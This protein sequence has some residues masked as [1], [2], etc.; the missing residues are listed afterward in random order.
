M[1]DI[2]IFIDYRSPRFIDRLR[3][4]IRSRNLSYATE[5]TYVYWVLQFIRFHQK[6]HPDT[7]GSMEIESFLSF[8]ATDRHCSKSTQ[9]TALNALI[10]LYQKFLSREDIGKLNFS[11]S[12]KPQ[13]IPTVFSKDEANL[14]I[15]QLTGKYK[16]M[17]QLIYG[18]GLRISELIR[19]RVKDIDFDM[20]QIIVRSGK[21][22]KDR[23]TLLPKILQQQLYE[24]ISLVELLH[25]QDIR[26]GHGE[27]YLPYAL[28]RKYKNAA[29]E[30]RWQYLFPSNNI[31]LDP[32]S[33]SEKWYFQTTPY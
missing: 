10:F 11:C 8:L 12:T 13:S 15:S 1:D 17:A 22:D 7:M 27:V 24:Q 6:R 16:M 31:S 29:K 28:S 4:C 25:Q 30:L 18:S 21:G 2:P 23:I 33:L 32:R 9:R 26:A 20:N 19:L 5:K 3:L 14:V